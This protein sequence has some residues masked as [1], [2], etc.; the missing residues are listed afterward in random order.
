MVEQI[1]TEMK[2]NMDKTIA[3]YQNEL[4]KIR[5]GR[6]S[7][8][9]LD[10]VNVD[11]YGTMQPLKN[12]AHISVPES[13]MIVITPFDPSSIEIIE[14][15]IVS[16]DLGMNPNNDGNVIRL[17]I[18]AL[19][20]ERRVEITKH[21]H[22]IIEEGRVSIRNIRRDVNDRIKKL[23]DDGISEDN[24]KRALDN[25]QETTD[26]SIKKLNSISEAKEKEIL[27]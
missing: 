3:Y 8:T 27:D 12:I 11:Y 16:S 19:T 7:V 17:S 14:S 23:K 26:D 6:A 5:T 24:I 18:P 21:V 9:M 15:S 22:K 25:V 13:Q 2:N 1:Y 20:E 10:S 4:S